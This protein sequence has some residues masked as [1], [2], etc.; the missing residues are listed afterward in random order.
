MTATTPVE[1]AKPAPTAK[2]KPVE[3]VKAEAK[4]KS[5]P[6]PKSAK[7]I[8]VDI[9]PGVSSQLEN[10]IKDYNARPGR[11]SPVLKYTDVVNMALD[12][13]LPALPPV[14]KG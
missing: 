3:K 10:Y 11:T 9:A 1:K 8:S 2:V 14:T 7:R 13:Y 4:V 5:E 6:K 12:N